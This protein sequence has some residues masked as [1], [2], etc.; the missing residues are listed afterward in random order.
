MNEDPLI[1]AIKTTLKSTRSFVYLL[2][3][4][5]IIDIII[6][7]EKLKSDISASEFSR[8][9]LYKEINPSLTV[10]D[11]F[12]CRKGTREDLKISFTQF[13]LSPHWLVV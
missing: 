6:A 2:I 5:D 8:R 7:I 4:Y 9:V 1:F 3:N 11:I 12:T 10:H 13:R